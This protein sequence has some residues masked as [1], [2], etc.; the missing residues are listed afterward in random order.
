MIASGSIWPL[1]CAAFQIPI[2]ETWLNNKSASSCLLL[3]GV[4]QSPGTVQCQHSKCSP[5]LIVSHSLIQHPIQSL[6]R[7]LISNFCSRS[8]QNMHQIISLAL[9]GPIEASYL[10]CNV[11]IIVLV[12]RLVIGLHT[13]NF[14]LVAVFFVV[15]DYCPHV[16]RGPK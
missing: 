7:Q 15:E 4:T 13:V 11:F 12:K 10:S 5:V 3:S 14:R 9:L 16:N 6:I 1:S 2:R 8:I